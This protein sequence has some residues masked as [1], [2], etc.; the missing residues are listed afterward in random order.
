MAARDRRALE[1]GAKSG[2]PDR[3]SGAIYSSISCCI[4]SVP[5][6]VARADPNM[7]RTTTANAPL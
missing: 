6:S 4:N 1:R 2:V 3:R 7:H 5:R